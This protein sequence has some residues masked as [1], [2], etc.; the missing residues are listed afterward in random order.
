MELL[1]TDFLFFELLFE[2][3]LSSLG[4][5]FLKDQVDFK[6]MNLTFYALNLSLPFLD[7]LL[8]IFFDISFKVELAVKF[9]FGLT[10]LYSS[11]F[12]KF[13]LGFL[14][15]LDCCVD[16]LILFLFYI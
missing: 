5:F 7:C 8:E 15:A 4:F 9:L 14:L 16:T 3:G 6:I 11:F 2:L 13:L 12:V 10:G 1:D